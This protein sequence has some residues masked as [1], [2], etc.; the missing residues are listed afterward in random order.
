LAAE[1]RLQVHKA[2]YKNMMKKGE[3]LV[4]CKS[5]GSRKKR[6]E[7]TLQERTVGNTIKPIRNLSRLVESINICRQ[8]LPVCNTRRRGPNLEG[9]KDP[10]T[11]IQ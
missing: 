6:E 4:C 5:S 11:M 9:S 10:Y 1:K 8:L 2:K 3:L 7:Q